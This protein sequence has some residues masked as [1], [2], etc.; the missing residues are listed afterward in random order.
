MPLY[1]YAIEFDRGLFTTNGFFHTTM[2]KE[3]S[4]SIVPSAFSLHIIQFEKN[5]F[6][7]QTDEVEKEAAARGSKQCNI[8]NNSDQKKFFIQM[9]EYFHL[10]FISSNAIA[11]FKFG[12]MH[13]VPL[14]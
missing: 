14:L 8:M 6:H 4:I 5:I 11:F 12:Y 3:I 9:C 2:A 13:S 10:T 1:M 7:S